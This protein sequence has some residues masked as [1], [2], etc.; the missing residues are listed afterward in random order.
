[1]SDRETVEKLRQDRHVYTDAEQYLN[2]LK[3]RL[4]YLSGELAGTF[5]LKRQG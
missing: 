1:M 4:A 2:Q 5:W 3:D